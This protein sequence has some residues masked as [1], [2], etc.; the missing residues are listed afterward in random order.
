MNQLIKEF[1]EKM[2]AGGEIK[3]GDDNQGW[4]QCDHKGR[5]EGLFLFY[6]FAF[7]VV[8]QL[9]LTLLQPHTGDLTEVA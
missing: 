8:G 2:A 9:R 6:F 3:L 4:H 5:L 7:S 1:D